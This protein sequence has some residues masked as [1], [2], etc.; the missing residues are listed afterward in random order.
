M[1]EMLF[2]IV[3]GIWFPYLLTHLYKKSRSTDRDFCLY[4]ISNAV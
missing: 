1:D 2:N 4:G 3:K